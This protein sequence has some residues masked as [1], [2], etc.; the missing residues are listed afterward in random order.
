MKLILFLTL[1]KFSILIF[2][3]FSLDVPRPYSS[4]VD[5]KIG[6]QIFG[7]QKDD[8]QVL[9]TPF[10][11]VLSPELLMDRSAVETNR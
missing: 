11:K 7:L 5:L 8:F 4:R 3:I 2:L 6:E 9:H 10:L 1:L